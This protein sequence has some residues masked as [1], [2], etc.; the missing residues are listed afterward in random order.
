MKSRLNER[1][2]ILD[3][4]SSSKTGQPPLG[5]AQDEN[6]AIAANETQFDDD[7]QPFPTLH[8]DT[9]EVEDVTEFLDIIAA[10]TSEV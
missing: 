5:C 1:Q 9:F 4:I 10:A 2:E 6:Q 3:L 8:Q 7:L